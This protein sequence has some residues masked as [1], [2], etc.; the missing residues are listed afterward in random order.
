MITFENCV[1]LILFCFQQGL[2]S[3]DFI[4]SFTCTMS[5]CYYSWTNTRTV[6]PSCVVTRIITLS[7]REV[8]FSFFVKFNHQLKMHSMCRFKALMKHKNTQR[9]CCIPFS[10]LYLTKFFQQESEELANKLQHTLTNEINL[11]FSH[12]CSNYPTK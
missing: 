3:I 11:Y 8:K 10:N 2:S 12:S 5:H 9:Y 1:E 6:R 7:Q 4:H